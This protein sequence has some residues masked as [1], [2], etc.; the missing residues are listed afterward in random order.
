MDRAEYRGQPAQPPSR[1]AARYRVAHEIPTLQGSLRKLRSPSPMN[2]LRL[3]VDLDGVVADFN[4]GWISRYND[5]FDAALRPDQVVTWDGLVPIT[6]FC[7]MEE[8][9]AWAR[10]GECSVFRELPL[11]DGAMETLARLARVHR[12]VVISSKYD[13]AIPDTLEW[14]AEH[15]LP[16]REIHFVWD[17]T[18]VDCDVYLEDAPHH[19]AALARVR[20]DRVICRMVR[21]WNTAVPGTVDV[22]DWAEFAA[23]VG[24][25]AA[26]A[27]T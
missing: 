14:L 20:S 8:F 5:H 6:H 12:P 18:S 2:G 9:W 3:G 22:R 11:Y 24:D 7:D 25:V 1:P 23:V 15:R 21:P 13:W 16:A 4:Q 10:A 19:L 17:K 26:A 27:R